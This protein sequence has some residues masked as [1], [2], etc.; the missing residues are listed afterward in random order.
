MLFFRPNSKICILQPMLEF[1]A[2]STLLR[3][4]SQ[5]TGFPVPHHLSTVHLVLTAKW[6]A[7]RVVASKP[8]VEEPP[9]RVSS[10]RY[11]ADG[12]RLGRTCRPSLR[13]GF[14]S[15]GP[16]RRLCSGPAQ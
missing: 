13:A 5:H 1:L 3:T 6:P 8:H 12:A 7:L 2:S 16:T 15:R 14:D 11:C 9:S 4:S 10:R